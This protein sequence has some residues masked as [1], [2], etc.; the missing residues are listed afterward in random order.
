M[1]DGATQITKRD[2]FIYQEMMSHV[3][4][5]AHGNAREVLIIGGGDCGIAEEVLK[6]KTVERLTQVEIDPA[7]VEFAKEHF[8][9]IHQA[10]VRRQ[11]L[12]K[13]YRR[14]HEICRADRTALRRHHRRLHRSARARESPVQPKILRRLQTLHEQ[15]R[16]HRDAERRADLAAAELAS[17]VEKFRRL[18]ADGAC[19]V[20]AI[21]T[22]VGGHMAM[23]WATDDRRLR[24]NPGEDAGGALSPGRQILYQILDAGSSRRCLRASALYRRNGAKARADGTL[25]AI[26]GPRNHRPRQTISCPSPF[27]TVSGQKPAFSRIANMH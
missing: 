12:R 7:V 24:A 5:F 26:G 14:R 25:A 3:P 22:Y 4:L 15:G 16:R 6:H 23:G 10:G 1:L 21:P 27:D 19:Y 11:A 13:R 9:R 18:F 20:A 8:P 17:S 2:E